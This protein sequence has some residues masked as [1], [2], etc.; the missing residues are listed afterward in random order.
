MSADLVDAGNRA[1]EGDCAGLLGDL[2]LS[3]WSCPAKAAATSEEES[4]H[5]NDTQI[6]MCTNAI[7]LAQL[8]DSVAFAR[9]NHVAAS[10]KNKMAAVINSLLRDT[11]LFCCCLDA[12]CII[13]L[14]CLDANQLCLDPCCA[15]CRQCRY[16]M[17]TG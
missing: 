17:Q 16:Y 6:C 4:Y 9:V 7:L 12:I 5:L 3:A 1:D 11:V 14:C 8:C 2:G 13:D 15:T 10:T